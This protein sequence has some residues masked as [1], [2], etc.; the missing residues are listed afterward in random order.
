MNP[1]SPYGSPYSNK[2]WTNPYA[3]TPQGFMTARVII[4]GDSVPIPT[5]LTPYPTPTETTVIHTH[6]TASIIPMEQ[7]VR[8]PIIQYMS[9]PHD[10]Y[11]PNPYSV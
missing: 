7:E 9:Y 4:E 10:N 5:T 2:S 6:L 1:Y 8:T 11:Q 3:T